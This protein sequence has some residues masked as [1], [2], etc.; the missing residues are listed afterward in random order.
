MKRSA[1]LLLLLGML[2]VFA[3]CA[4]AMTDPPAEEPAADASAVRSEPGESSAQDPLVLKLAVSFGD[5]DPCT[6]SVRAFAESVE[7]RT[8]G[9]VRIQVNA[10][11]LLGSDEELIL[12]SAQ[13]KDK[14]DIIIAEAFAFSN[15]EP[16]MGVSALPFLF[17]DEE[18][19]QA[20]MDGPVEARAEEKLQE[21]GMRVMAHYDNGFRCMTN[22]ARPI[23]EPGDLKDLRICCPIGNVLVEE[24]ILSFDAVP[25]PVRMS[26]LYTELMLRNCDGQ[27]NTLQEISRNRLNEVQPFLTLTNH[28]YCGLC[29]TVSERAWNRL[30]AEEQRVITEEALAS[31]EANRALSRER[32]ENLLAELAAIMEIGSPDL[33]AFRTMA[34][35]V[36]AENPTGISDELLSMLSAQSA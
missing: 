7:E 1:A 10:A 17:A 13:G 30:S 14:A 27:E 6:V 25:Q 19:A 4:A 33:T 3:G 32:T 15:I 8:E 9:R 20:F 29:L 16:D 26:E 23:I 36:Y 11:G 12:A 21:K 2:L 22:S 31:A 34:E 24:M 28:I 35:R 18:E 5:D